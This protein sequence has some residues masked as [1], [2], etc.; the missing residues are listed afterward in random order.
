MEENKFDKNSFIGMLLIGGIFL[1]YMTTFQEEPVEETTKT[2]EVVNTENINDNPSSIQEVSAPIENEALVANYGTFAP[3]MSV[4]GHEESF[5]EINNGVLKLKFSNKGGYL[6]YAELLDYDDYKGKPVVLIE[7]STANLNLIFKTTDNR[8]IETQNLFFS[9]EINRQSE[10]VY[11]TMKAVTASGESLSF[12]YDIKDQDYMLG[13]QIESNGFKNIVSSSTNPLLKWELLGLR[14]EKSLQYENQ[15]STLAYGFSGDDDYLSIA[16]EDEET[17][18]NVTWVGF[19]QHFF[20]NILIPEEAFKEVNLKSKSLFEDEE[21]DSL[22]SKDFKMHTAINFKG[23]EI[24]EN[25]DYYIGPNDYYTLKSYNKEVE[26]IIDLGWGIFGTINKYAFVP[27]FE[28]LSK[29]LS[30]YG[31]IIILMTIIVRIFMSPLVYKSY[32]S[33]AKMKILRPEMNEI[34]EKY[35]KKEDAMKRQQEI[36]AVQKKAGVS[37]LSGCIPALLQMPVFFALFRFFPSAIKLRG[38]GFLWADDLA[39]YDSVFQLPF[40]IPLYGDHVSLFPILASIAIFFYMQM[41]QSQQMNMQQPTQEG[42]PDMSK[43]MKYMM[44]FS[45]LMMLFFFNNYA[46]GLS[47]YYFISNLLTITIMLVIKNVIINEDKLHAQIEENK[48]KPVKQSKFRQRLD[49][50]MKQAQEQQSKRK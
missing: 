38:Q 8:E 44:Y 41:N 15:Q 26:S 45:P 43:M 32:V 17:E 49:E 33:S 9:S 2:E 37:M 10:H 48:K 7:P 11:L 27:L 18:E 30:N 24:D 16:S 34:N 47:L 46:S 6:A 50:A 28:F 19:K 29:H 23:G 14:Q 36:M 1:W 3:A 5:T 4:A 12:V 25:F 42:M 31:L 20:S 13:M 39:S 22:Y 35:P 21:T 40:S